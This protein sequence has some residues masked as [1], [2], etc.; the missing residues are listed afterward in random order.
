MARGNRDFTTA[1]SSY[2]DRGTVY[3]EYNIP[4]MGRCAD[5]IVL[6]DGVIFVLKYKTAESRFSREAVLQVWDY[7]IDLKNFQE[8]S[9]C[10][11]IIPIL[12][13]PG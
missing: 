1:I 5:V 12:V 7:A 2:K 8:G 11:T 13:V 10:R 6:I 9:A 3:F 4:R